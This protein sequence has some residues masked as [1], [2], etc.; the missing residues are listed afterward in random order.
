MNIIYLRYFKLLNKKEYPCLK[1]IVKLGSFM[2]PLELCA[3]FCIC[4][5]SFVCV[6]RFHQKLSSPWI[7]AENQWV[8]D[9]STAGGPTPLPTG[10]IEVKK[11]G[12]E[13]WMGPMVD[14]GAQAPFMG[15]LLLSSI[16]LLSRSER[17]SVARVSRF[18][19]RSQ[20]PDIGV[21]SP[22]SWIFGK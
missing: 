4:I 11:M 9:R 5:Y 7:S 15:Q 16:W 3:K 20:N 21:K 8:Y 19:N 10:A 17:S 2:R 14:Q 13:G 22:K 6:H 18:F 12:K 1:E